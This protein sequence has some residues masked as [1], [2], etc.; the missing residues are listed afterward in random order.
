MYFKKFS[1]VLQEIFIPAMRCG[2]DY[3]DTCTY[4]S[5]LLEISVFL[6]M[7]VRTSCTYAHILCT[8]VKVKRHGESHGKLKLDEF[9][10]PSTCVNHELS[11]F[12][13]HCLI[14][15][16]LP[17]PAH[18]RTVSHVDASVWNNPCQAVPMIRI[19]PLKIHVGNGNTGITDLQ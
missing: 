9:P 13:W 10:E 5:K 14:S 18:K 8:Y 11:T 1:Y 19:K 7:H 3:S 16:D 12:F 17:E 6:N 4:S 15:H 2:V